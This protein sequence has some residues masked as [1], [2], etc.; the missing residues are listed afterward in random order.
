MTDPTFTA[1]QLI[2]NARQLYDV[3]H[4]T[5]VGAFYGQ[6]PMTVSQGAMRIETWLGN[7]VP[8][9]QAVV[10]ETVV[11]SLGDIL[12]RQADGKFAAVD[13]GAEGTFLAGHGANALPT[14]EAPPGSDLAIGAEIGSITPTTFLIADDDGTLQSGP[15]TGSVPLLRDKLVPE[16]FPPMS[17]LP[18]VN[19]PIFAVNPYDEAFG[20]AA[21]EI[22]V[23]D[24]HMT[25]GSHVL[26]CTTSTPFT[27]TELNA[28]QAVAVVGVG[29]SGAVLKTTITSITDSGHAVL[30]ATAS[31]TAST[32]AV[33]FGTDNTAPINAAMLA[34]YSYISGDPFFANSGGIVQLMP[35]SH[36]TTGPLAQKSNVTLAGHPGAT[37]ISQ[38]YGN[39][40]SLWTCATAY[41]NTY[42]VRGVRFDGNGKYQTATATAVQFQRAVGG[43]L[44]NPPYTPAYFDPAPWFSGDNPSEI[45]GGDRISFEDCTIWHVNG[46]AIAGNGYAIDINRF[47]IMDVSLN[48]MDTDG[49][50]D[51]NFS[52][53]QVGFCGQSCITEG[54]ANNRWSTIKA[55]QSG[56]ANA[57]YPCVDFLNGG[58]NTMIGMEVQQVW[59]PGVRFFGNASGN[60]FEGR[61]DGCIGDAVVMQNGPVNNTVNVTVTSFAGHNATYLLLCSG[62]NNDITING[63]GWT[64]GIMHGQVRNNTIRINN[65]SSHGVGFTKLEAAGHVDADGTGLTDADD[66]YVPRLGRM[67]HI[68]SAAVTSYAE[69]GSTSNGPGYAT[70]GT[71]GVGHDSIVTDVLA[72][73]ARPA[74]AVPFM[75]PSGLVVL[76]G[77]RYDA[78]NYG[79]TVP[80]T[81]ACIAHG[82]RAVISRFLSCAVWEDDDSDLT[83]TGSWASSAAD[84][85][86][87][88]GN[89]R[90][91]GANGDLVTLDVPAGW[92]GGM[93]VLGVKCV[94]GGHGAI[95]TV[96]VDGSTVATIDSR[97]VALTSTEC[98][99][100]VRYPVAAGASA[101]TVTISS[102]AT[103]AAFDYLAL[104]MPVRTTGL[105]PGY[106]ADFPYA[107]VLNS[108][109]PP[110]VLVAGETLLPTYTTA[111]QAFALTD[112]VMNDC[113]LVLLPVVQE[114]ASTRVMFIDRND[115]VTYQGVA[116]A[117]MFQAN[118]AYLSPT[119][120]ARHAGTLAQYIAAA[121]LSMTDYATLA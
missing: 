79:I 67:L 112:N 5:A 6:D 41:E 34:A 51:C 29:A 92:G 44:A 23:F 38:Q 69:T 89:T 30:A 50:A 60:R 17:W 68:P 77:C 82:L 88:G 13:A 65:T 115:M 74:R 10:D 96:K 71:S 39:A 111:G 35:G 121:G 46:T 58:N 76:D 70:V 42:S 9:G 48:G 94:A 2:D 57:G 73:V 53:G 59:G 26:Q 43:Q 102:F 54:G 78:M 106:T 80:Q 14:M 93:G 86:F 4:P 16:G 91:A 81:D 104:E 3:D 33:Q 12:V 117:A 101:I 1:Q 83:F 55:Y 56:E 37:T 32:C 22:R 19:G 40:Y 105:N 45:A 72:Q 87:S 75:S 64:L 90:A 109:S 61:I 66:G 49:F 7:V 103:A 118:G 110:L 97:S 98:V 113:T 116:D 99:G 85:G 84:A 27:S 31:T 100:T 107:D 8:K 15:A 25:S 20:A 119:G 108:N 36:L 52:N 62:Y 18:G 47:F 120:A 114:Y 24:G 11:K 28:G 21:D 63:I 95:F